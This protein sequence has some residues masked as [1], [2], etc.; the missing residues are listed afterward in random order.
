MGHL[1]RYIFKQLLWWTLVIAISL[2][3]IVWLTQ[4]LRFVD[5]IVKI[6][7]LKDLKTCLKN[8]FA[9]YKRT[10]YLIKDQLNARHK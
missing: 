9:L 2:T 4:S 1:N 3:C 8:D 10:F 7:A 6:D 5:M